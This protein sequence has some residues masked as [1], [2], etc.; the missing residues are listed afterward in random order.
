MVLDTCG[1]CCLQLVDLGSKCSLV[2]LMI[3][4]LQVP[5]GGG[6]WVMVCD[7]ITCVKPDQ[8]LSD[9]HPDVLIFG[10]KGGVIA[11]SAEKPASAFQPCQFRHLACFVKPLCLL[12]LERSPLRSRC[13]CFGSVW[14][15]LSSVWVFT[16]TLGVDVKVLFLPFPQ[17]DKGNKKEDSQNE[18][19]GEDDDGV[20]NEKQ[21]ANQVRSRLFPLYFV[22]SRGICKSKNTKSATQCDNCV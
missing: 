22:C 19:Y 6:Q 20:E 7:V 18:K 17:A 21:P 14:C 3:G 11:A 10:R 12:K 1:M 4:M 15:A 8:T 9:L 13:S 16:K 5:K 2:G